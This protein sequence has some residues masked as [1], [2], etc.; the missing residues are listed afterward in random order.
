M[1]LVIL[2]DDIEVITSVSSSF[3]KVGLEMIIISAFS[4][5]VCPA[6]VMRA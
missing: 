6:G 3:L 4:S 2:E 1:T 5:T